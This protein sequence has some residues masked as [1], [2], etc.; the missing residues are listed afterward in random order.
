MLLT[1]PPYAFAF[2]GSLGNSIHAGKTNERA[3]HVAIPMCISMI[4]NILCITITANAGRY[5]A[6]F[7]MTL[8]VYSAFNVTYSW[9]SST[10]SAP[11]ASR[12]PHT[13][14]ENQAA[15]PRSKRAAAL[16]MVNIMGNAT[17]LFSSYL[18]PDSDE[19]RYARAGIT[20]SFFCGLGAVASIALRFWLRHENQKLD[21]LEG[22]MGDDA[23]NANRR[24]GF[25]YI[26]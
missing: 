12:S 26:L 19:P 2:F 25:R 21:L 5:V 14:A 24:K 23:E 17:H 18:Y 13:D 9:V 15:R 4:G 10:V 6:M 20:L 8:G 16:A 7:L 3:F 1:A 11:K 22:T